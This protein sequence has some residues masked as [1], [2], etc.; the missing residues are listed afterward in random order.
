MLLR[1]TFFI[2]FFTN[3]AIGQDTLIS[4]TLKE[5]VVTSY[6]KA[7]QQFY[8]PAS[9]VVIDSLALNN[10]RDKSLL[11]LANLNPGIRMEERSPGSFR[12]SIRG[13]LLRSPFGIR[14]VKFYF[15]EFPLTDAGGNTYL[16]LF[17]HSLF[18]GIEILKGPDGSIFGA[19][20]GGVVKLLHSPSDDIIS[21]KMRINSGSYGEIYQSVRTDINLKKH[22]ITFFESYRRNDGYRMNSAIRNFNVMIYDKIN[23]S[24][25]LAV[26]VFGFISNLKYQTPGGLTK[27]QAIDD[28][29]QSRPATAFLP[30][31]IE[32]QAR[33]ENR[34]GWLGA[35]L[36]Y[37][38]NQRFTFSA[39]ISSM[40]TRFSNPFITNYETRKESGANVRM[41]LMIENKNVNLIRYKFV[42]GI[43][44]AILHSAIN[45][46]ENI[47]GE[48]G[49]SKASDKII[50]NYL[51]IFSSA[52]AYIGNRITTQIS[53]SENLN[54]VL[55]NGIFPESGI[56]QINYTPQLM[57]K[58]SI[59]YSPKYF[60]VIRGVISK[61]YSVPTTAEIRPSGNKINSSLNPEI[62]WNYEAG[63]RVKTKNRLFYTDIS[64]FKY[65]LSNTISRRIDE[66]ETEFFINSGNTSQKGLEI[67]TN[68]SFRL[69][70]QGKVSLN[71]GNG[72]TLY[73]FRFVNFISGETDLTNKKLT[74]IPDQAVSST[75]ELTK[76]DRWSLSITHYFTG[77]IPLNDLSTD[78]AA[79]NNLFNLK[80][81]K[82]FRGKKFLW[83]VFTQVENLTNVFYISGYDLNAFSGR[84]Y[85]P[86][87][88]Q[89]F[90][91]GIFI[92]SLFKQ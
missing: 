6:F 13:S 2:L 26:D 35:Q 67:Q 69:N 12:F 28:P 90:T 49:Q 68:F 57:P 53:L 88:R 39:A 77:S 71:I 41:W 17:D 61:G 55:I 42:T 1:L 23:L 30:S 33:I 80:V 27:Q 64:I 8:Q 25:K 31:A 82:K 29:Q 24:E 22:Q 74:G 92:E 59:S 62:G 56:Q 40:H 3:V 75:I 38:I 70:D 86:A 44:G 46:F 45:N 48:A 84:Y 66:N 32:Q 16:N 18:S 73:D 51:V 21:V 50:N 43:E 72:I 5:V 14:N 9:S 87:A 15:N 19:N 10:S 54:A 60:F 47:S 76:K 91:A 52:T 83:S 11:H 81:E 79:E 78:V 89:N 58:F 4:S 20:S 65:N 7:E 63:L 34:T 37:K 85:N 36:N